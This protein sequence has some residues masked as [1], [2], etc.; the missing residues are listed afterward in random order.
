MFLSQ[1]NGLIYHNQRDMQCDNCVLV[2]LTG[3][4]NAYFVELCLLHGISL[5]NILNCVNY[6]EG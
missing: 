2:A 6:Q 1:Q 5:A 4:L 3:K